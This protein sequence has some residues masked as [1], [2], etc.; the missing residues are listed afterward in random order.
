MLL[1][2][3]KERHAVTQFSCSPRIKP[4]ATCNTVTKLTLRHNSTESP[5]Y[6]AN[7][8][9]YQSYG[10]T[11]RCKWEASS[12]IRS[13]PVEVSLQRPSGPA[14]SPGGI[15]IL[16]ET[17][18]THESRTS[19]VALLFFQRCFCA[20]KL[21]GTAADSFSFVLFCSTFNAALK[22]WPHFFKRSLQF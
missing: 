16:L 17:H 11:G 2:R 21:S 14:C 8:L 9:H 7:P 12:F 1:T 3:V 6:S 13:Q 5:Q 20:G 22:A 10:I 4:K 19:R 15:A 18:Q